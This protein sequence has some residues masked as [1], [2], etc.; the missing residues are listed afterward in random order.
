MKGRGAMGD[1]VG[2][3]LFDS[4]QMRTGLVMMPKG[5]PVSLDSHLKV[6]D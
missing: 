1:C 3:F 6:R 5:E 2:D 4:R